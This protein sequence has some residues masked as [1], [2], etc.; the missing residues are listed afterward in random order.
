MSRMSWRKRSRALT[1]GLA[2]MLAGPLVWASTQEPPAGAPAAVPAGRSSGLAQESRVR[3]GLG[4]AGLP[5]VNYNTDTGLGYGARAVLYDYGPGQKPYRYSVTLQFFQT[6]NGLMLHALAL[7]APALAGSAWRLETVFRVIGDRFSPYYGLGNNTVYEPAFETCSSPDAL[8]NNPDV[9]PGN[10]IFRGVH[11]YQFQ[12][13]IADASIKARRDLGRDWRLLLV[14]RPRLT[15]IEVAYP[16]V[17]GQ[18]R[19][20]KLVEDWQAGENL[21]GLRFDERGKPRPVRTGEVTVGILYDSRTPEFSPVRGMFHELSGRWADRVVGSQL[22]Y[23][24]GNLT[25]RAYRHLDD[26]R[27]LVAAGRLV[28][29]YLGGDVPFYLLSSTGGLDGPQAIGG[30]SSLRGL[31]RNRFVG[32]LKA[33][34]NAELRWTFARFQPGRHDLELTGVAGLDVGRAWKDLAPDAPWPRPHHTSVA[35]LRLIWDDAFIVRV[36]YGRAWSQRSS[37]LYVDFFHVF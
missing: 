5:L 10:P 36:D 28:A 4:M 34:A 15:F 14:Y 23:W 24:G 7:D 25:L 12:S 30:L 18:S 29:D 35:G 6:T 37:G 17:G 3:T 19:D 16:S 8:R 9:C 21:P 11:Y 31:R 20:S 13:L 2:A 27:R 22:A 33:F 1:A 26:G 32:R